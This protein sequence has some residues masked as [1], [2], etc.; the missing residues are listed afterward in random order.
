MNINFQT[1]NPAQLNDR[2]TELQV[3][4]T[5]DETNNLQANHY[6]TAGALAVGGVALLNTGAASNFTL[7]APLAG[8]QNAGGQDFATMKILALDAHAYVV[9]TPADKI[10]GADDTATWTAAVG[11][12]MELIA[13]NGVWYSSRL[14]GVTLSEV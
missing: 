12:G 14:T 7:A 5:L 4:V 6:T 13:Y 3:A 2:V 9:T 10:N 8:A 1:T 11:N